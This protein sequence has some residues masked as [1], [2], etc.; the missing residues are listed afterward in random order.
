ML[1][2]SHGKGAR[3]AIVRVETAPPSELP[4]GVPAPPNGPLESEPRPPDG[5]FA[6]GSEAARLAGAASG[7]RRRAQAARIRALQGLGLPE[8][9]P[10]W[11]KPYEAMAT[12]FVRHVTEAL[13]V[14]VGG[15][16]C[17]AFAAVL[18][19]NAALALAGSRAAYDVADPALGAKLADSARTQI[20]TAWE[21]T[22]RAA[23]NAQKRGA[24][25]PPALAKYLDLYEAQAAAHAHAGKGAP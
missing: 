19:Q 22:A 13:A 5:R 2:K 17:P 7:A 8:G 24:K 11:L 4:N 23:S 25:V 6:A 9:T 18:V 20:L 16:E 14:T 12:E 15:G 10:D 1:R 3:S 21:L